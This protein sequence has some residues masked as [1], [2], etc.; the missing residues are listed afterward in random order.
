MPDSL[1]TR[2]WLPH[3]CAANLSA[4]RLYED[5]ETHPSFGEG[6]FYIWRLSILSGFEDLDV[7]LF[8]EEP[9][10]QDYAYKEISALCRLIPDLD[11]KARKVAE[12]SDA[13][14][15]MGYV[16]CFGPWVKVAYF[17]TAYNTQWDVLFEFREGEGLIC[18]GIKHSGQQQ[19][20][21]AA[22]GGDPSP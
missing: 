10:D 6:E 14:E 8:S 4:D 15:Y 5:R 18:H 7:S 1:H 21:I 2:T 3:W 9:L 19:E 16:E 11:D 13:E 17:A 20:I 12:G 22:A